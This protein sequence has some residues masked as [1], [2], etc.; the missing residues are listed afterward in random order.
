MEE[1]EYLVR[2]SVLTLTGEEWRK[3]IVPREHW[4]EQ[5]VKVAERGDVPIYMK[6]NLK[7]YWSGELRQ[8][9]PK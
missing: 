4:I 9:F 5:I 1:T 3:L 8:E 7:P 2:R 6:D